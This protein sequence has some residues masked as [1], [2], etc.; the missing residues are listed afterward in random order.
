MTGDGPTL[1]PALASSLVDGAT[2]N[3]VVPFCSGDCQARWKWHYPALTQE[4]RLDR[5]IFT[6]E[7]RRIVHG[8]AEGEPRCAWCTERLVP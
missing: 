3:F 2:L 5:E 1:F 7:P 8:V 4:R 6:T